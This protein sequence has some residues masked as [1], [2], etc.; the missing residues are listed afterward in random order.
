[1]NG[2]EDTVAEIPRREMTRA[3][4]EAGQGMQREKVS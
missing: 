4:A 3:S 2:G 1:M